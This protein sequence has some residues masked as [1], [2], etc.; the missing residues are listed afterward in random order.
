MAIVLDLITRALMEIG[1]Y[2]AGGGPGETPTAEDAQLALAYFQMQL[3]AWNAERETL[4]VQARV[5][6]TLK[7]GTSYISIGP[8]GEIL[9]H[10]P[11][12]LDTV[13]YVIPGTWPEIEV[14]LGSLTD[15]D[16]ACIT[17]KSLPNALPLQFYYQTGP[18][19]G[20][21]FFWPQVTQDLKVYLYYLA[22]EDIPTAL[23]SVVNGP[24]GYLEAFHYQ[25]A[26]RLLTPFGV[27]NPA[28]ISLVTTHSERAYARMKRPNADPGQRDLDPAVVGGGGAYNV[29]ADTI[30]GGR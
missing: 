23:T 3:D 19:N 2:S 24:S 22:N 11:T 10:R 28:V 12:W 6:F 5:G 14:K 21:L 7:A 15:D 26:E 25:L 20:E 17:I 29:L 13:K 27:S 16:Y 1:A 9:A 4:I 8:S 18:V 30:T